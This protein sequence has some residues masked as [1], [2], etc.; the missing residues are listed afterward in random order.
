LQWQFHHRL[1]DRVYVELE[2]ELHTVDVVFVVDVVSDSHVNR[3]LVVL[4]YLG[5][6][7]VAGFNSVGR[8]P[9]LDLRKSLSGSQATDEQVC[10]LEEYADKAS[11]HCKVV[12]FERVPFR[13]GLDVFARIDVYHDLV[14]VYF[15]RKP[16]LVFVPHAVLPVSNQTFPPI[17]NFLNKTLRVRLIA[18]AL[19]KLYAFFSF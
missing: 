7:I 11:T 4:V 15:S 8:D 13:T 17:Q 19:K 2:F 12:V 3:A 18:H 16:V 10:G 6:H 9:V 14:R 5:D 1:L